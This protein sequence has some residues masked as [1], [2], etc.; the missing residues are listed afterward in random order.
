MWNFAKNASPFLYSSWPLIRGKNRKLLGCLELADFHVQNFYV[1]QEILPKGQEMKKKQEKSIWKAKP[2]AGL[3]MKKR[4]NTNNYR[5]STIKGQQ[6]T[7][8]QGL[9]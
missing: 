3:M 2:Q 1:H 6:N 9:T 7:E 8:L 4:K 5:Q